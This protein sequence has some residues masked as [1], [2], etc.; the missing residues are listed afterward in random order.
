MYLTIKTIASSQN[1]SMSV[2]SKSETKGADSAD[3]FNNYPCHSCY[4]SLP[5]QHDIS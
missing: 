4:S 3:I 2:L 5:Y 1:I